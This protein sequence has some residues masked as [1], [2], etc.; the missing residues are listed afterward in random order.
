MN[1]LVLSDAQQVI[2][3]RW[4]ERQSP[5]QERILRLARDVLDFISATGQWYPFADF[6]LD[7][8]HRAVQSSAEDGPQEL[9][10]LLIQTER[11]FGKL[12]DEPTAAGEQASIQLILDAFRF[13]SSTRQ[14][15]A[16]G[17]FVEHVEFH[18]P[19][20]VV[21]SFESQ[22]EAEAWLENHPAPPAFA[23]ILIGGRYHDVVYERETDFRRLPWNRDLERYLAWLKRVEPPVAAAEFATR[24]EAEA[25]LRSQPNPS[26][27]V[28]V[29]IAGEFFLAAYHPNINHR[30]LYPLS[31]AEGYEE[32]AEEGP[33]D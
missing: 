17:D 5:E 31:M 18:A 19:P 33:G 29:T 26:R 30:A 6:R 22:E 23:D 16:F 1:P 13:I 21:A 4:R 14:Y 27:R 10:E 8:G 11:Y 2:G 3:R 28:W 25:W 7:D 32:E 24:E 20:F 15:S 9:R 12:L